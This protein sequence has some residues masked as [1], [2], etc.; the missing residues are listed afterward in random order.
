MKLV[1]GE[2]FE[3]VSD[4]NPGAA[5]IAIVYGGYAVFETYDEY[6]TWQNQK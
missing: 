3:K 4:E 1:F 5:M 2:S 6:Q